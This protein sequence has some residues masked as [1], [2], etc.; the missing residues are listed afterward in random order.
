MDNVH[1]NIHISNQP[2]SQ[3]LRDSQNF[4]YETSWKVGRRNHT[5]RWDE[6]IRTDIIRDICKFHNTCAT[7]YLIANN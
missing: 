3:T 6:D 4:N 1:H 7:L 2:L 5:C